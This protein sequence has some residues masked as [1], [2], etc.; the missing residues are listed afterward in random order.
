MAANCQVALPQV[1]CG[2]KP[3]VEITSDVSL[4]N[5]IMEEVRP[6]K[7]ERAACLGFTQN[8]WRMLEQCWL[9]DRSARPSV[10]DILPCLNDAALHWDVRTTTPADE[11]SGVASVAQD[12]TQFST[13][14]GSP[15]TGAEG[16]GDQG[17]NDLGHFPSQ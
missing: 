2:H 17:P 13:Q 3:Y 6:E 10:E 12:Q 5:A 15:L 16:N 11:G 4:M 14:T 8:L 9:E 7:P 1:L